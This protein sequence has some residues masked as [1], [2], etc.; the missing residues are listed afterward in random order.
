[1]AETKTLEDLIKLTLSYDPDSGSMTW[2][3]R[4]KDLFTAS[5]K[6]TAEHKANNWN[7]KH[8]GKEA[9]TCVGGH[10][11]RTGTLMGKRHLL[12][13]VAFVLVTGGWPKMLVDH[14]NGDKLDNRWVNLREANYFQNAH[15]R[16]SHG[17]TCQYVGVYWNKH[18]GGYFGGVYHKGKRHYCGFSKTDP[19]KVA[20]IRDAKARE[21]LVNM[22]T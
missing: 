15:N 13:R 6:R 14:I 1:M 10:G 17:K 21:L 20:R 9:F 12:H 8:A 3:E 11:Y 5:D 18:L 7:S 4:T 16:S 19:E 22:R 2:K